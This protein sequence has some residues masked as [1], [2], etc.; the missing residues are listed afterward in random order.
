M[1]ERRAQ[2]DPAV[3]V[4]SPAAAAEPIPPDEPPGP[5]PA[6]RSVVEGGGRSLARGLAVLG[7]CRVATLALQLVALGVVAAALHPQRLGIYLFALAFAGVFTLVTNFGFQT[8]V[9]REV[10][11]RPDHE[12]WLLPNLV[13]ARVALAAGAYGL[14]WLVLVVTSYSAPTRHATLLAAV[15]LFVGAFDGFTI[16]LQVRVRMLVVGLAALSQAAVLC[17]GALVLRGVHGSVGEFVLLDV[18]ATAL[19]VT[20]VAGAAARVVRFSW[21]IRP[22]AWVPI[23]RAALP[24][25]AAGAAIAIYYRLDVLILGRLEPASAVGQYGAG[26]RFIDALGVIPTILVTV[27]SPVFARSAIGPVAVFERRYRQALHLSWLL[28]LPV[29]LLGAMLAWRVLPQVPGFAQYGEAGRVL[30]VLAPAGTCIIV[31]NV[32][33]SA[34]ISAGQQSRLMRV[35]A[36]VLVVNVVA[37]LAL[38]PPFSDIG[39]AAAT[40]FSEALVVGLSV[41]AVRRHVGLRWLLRDPLRALPAA[42]LTAMV[43][44]VTYGLEPFVQLIVCGIAYVVALLVTPALRAGDLAGLLG[45]PG[46]VTFV[47][48]HPLAPADAE[49]LCSTWPVTEHGWRWVVV[50]APASSAGARPSRLPTYRLVRLWRALRGS[51]TCVLVDLPPLRARVVKAVVV[52]AG[53]TPVDDDQ[54]RR[55]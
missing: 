9:A 44:A 7:A 55:R 29:G 33:S 18:G 46:P 49:R 13:Y 24:L 8:I 34:L 54:A 45:K 40:T 22:S 53:C 5:Q 10:A 37:N 30:S 16:A 32:L 11:Q 43:A 14:V 3:I 2:H 41:R 19:Q 20:L 21:G 28:A 27:L 39:A 36:A 26:Y 48:A 38:I 50:A 23:A 6:A 12:A 4:A 47:A 15:G 17:V 31:A 25:G 1:P 35:S 51:S 42:V 52:A